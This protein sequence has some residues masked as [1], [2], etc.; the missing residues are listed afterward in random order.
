VSTLP[1]RSLCISRNP[2]LQRKTLQDAGVAVQHYVN[3]AQVPFEEA[4]VDGR[5]AAHQAELQV[6]RAQFCGPW[7]N[8]RKASPEPVVPP[9]QAP[10]G[11]RKTSHSLARLAA[12]LTTRVALFTP[13]L[14][15]CGK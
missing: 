3:G 15:R 1:P 13:S 2:R 6:R 14:F 8:E 10:N 11:R 4:T 5:L 12:H 9:K 7:S